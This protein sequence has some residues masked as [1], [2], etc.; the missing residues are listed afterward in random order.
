MVIRSSVLDSI[1]FKEKLI[2]MNNALMAA[3]TPADMLATNFVILLK[4]LQ[5]SLAPVVLS[6][7]YTF[8]QIEITSWMAFKP[9]LSLLIHIGLGAYVI[10]N[11]KK[12]EAAVFGI[13]FYLITLFLSSNLVVKI[14]STMAERFL[15][16][17]TL[18]FLIALVFIVSKILKTDLRSLNAS[19]TKIFSGAAI[20]MVLFSFKTYSRIPVWQNNYTLFLSGVETSPNSARTHYSLASESRTRAEIERDPVVREQLFKQS[21]DEYFKGIEIYPEY[22]GYYNL[23]VTYMSMNQAEKAEE[24]Y[25]KTLELKSTYPPALNN[26]GVINFNRKDYDKAEYFF[27]EVLKNDSLHADATANLGAIYHNKGN[28]QDAIN[29]YEKA[30]KLNPNN[31]NVHNNII[32]VYKNLNVPEM[33]Q[34]Y[35]NSL[36]RI[37]R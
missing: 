28:Y 35:Q 37:Q 5:L 3:K 27:R 17:P 24:A 33:V 36:N 4:Y 34:Y 9:I 13:L 32:K 20:V 1:T 30:L 21:L 19:A 12:R 8:N 2:V 26:M 6:W 25:K 22:D 29:M 15:Y 7:D 10:L 23:G 14:G 16:T 31:I 11:F 18:G